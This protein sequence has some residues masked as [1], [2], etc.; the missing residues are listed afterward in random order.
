MWLVDI[1][2]VSLLQCYNEFPCISLLTA[3]CSQVLVNTKYKEGIRDHINEFFLKEFNDDKLRPFLAVAEEWDQRGPEKRQSSLAMEMFEIQ[4]AQ[5]LKM[6]ESARLE[7]WVQI[8]KDIFEDG[9]LGVSK[10][11]Y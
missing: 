9:Q 1:Q 2:V 10:R 8:W 7:I 3:T 11:Q 6:E 5:G 4:A